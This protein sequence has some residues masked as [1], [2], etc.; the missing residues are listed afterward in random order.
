MILRYLEGF[1]GIYSDTKG[2]KWDLKGLK[3]ILRDLGILGDLE[4]LK[5]I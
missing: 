3:G 4:G 1:T 5:G 2:F